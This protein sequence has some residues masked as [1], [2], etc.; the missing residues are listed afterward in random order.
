MTS[1]SMILLQAA[2]QFSG[3]PYTVIAFSSAAECSSFLR[4]V[5]DMI[6]QYDGADGSFRISGEKVMK[7]QGVDGC[8]CERQPLHATVV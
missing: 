2:V 5:Y 4:L 8:T 6:W 1:T 7:Y 3:W